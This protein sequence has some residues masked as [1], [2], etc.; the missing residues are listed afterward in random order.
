LSIYPKVG[1][2]T[3]RI[4]RSYRNRSKGPDGFPKYIIARR[5][6]NGHVI[7]KSDEKYSV[8]KESEEQICKICEDTMKMGNWSWRKEKIKGRQET[9]KEK[10]V[11]YS[12]II[13]VILLGYFGLMAIGI[14]PIIITLVFVFFIVMGIIDGRTQF[15]IKD[16]ILTINKNGFRYRKVNLNKIHCFVTIGSKGR[17]GGSI[18][19]N[20]EDIKIMLV[21][22]YGKSFFDDSRENLV[23]V[24]ELESRWL[25]AY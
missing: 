3:K 14:S 15:I 11:D 1:R 22:N 25:V 12:V 6:N 17:I 13:F 2:L 10:I 16:N 23:L 20:I 19:K 5:C 24:N 4:I 8:F 21:D 7:G 18:N 9:R